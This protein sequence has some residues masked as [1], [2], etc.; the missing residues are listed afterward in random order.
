MFFKMTIGSKSA[1]QFLL[2]PNALELTKTG[3]EV[4]SPSHG[5]KSIKAFLERLKTEVV[6]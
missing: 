5:Q 2:T 6:P 4:A 3:V 1:L